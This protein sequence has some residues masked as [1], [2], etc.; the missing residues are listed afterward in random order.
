MALD[1]LALA[2]AKA[3]GKRPYFY[4]DPDVERVQAITMAVAMELAVMRERMDTIE[5]LLDTKGV[6][7][8]EDIERFEPS[9]AQADERGA[10]TQEYLARILRIVQQEAEAISIRNEASS[11]DVAEELAQI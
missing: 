2:G 10:W 8:R 11:E 4:K 9:K 1:P 7:R 3:K 5:R 6:V